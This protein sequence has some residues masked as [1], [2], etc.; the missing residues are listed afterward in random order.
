MPLGETITLFIADGTSDGRYEARL[1]NWNA[2]AYKIPRGLLKR[3]N[4]LDY[5]HTPGIYFLFG[6]DD[7]SERPFVYVGEA[8]DP[9]K[10]MNQPHPFEKN[11]NWYWTEVVL[12]VS[13]DGSLD[14]AKI[15]YLE[16]RFHSIA[17]EAT[18]YQ[19]L[20]SN[21]PTQPQIH[22]SV[23]DQLERFIQNARLVMPVLGH[24]VFEPLPS[25]SPD[26]HCEPADDQL[27]LSQTGIKAFGRRQ[28]DGFWVLRGSQ[29]RPGYA[30][31]VP[32]GIKKAREKYASLINADNTLENDI[33][34]GSP[35]YAAMFVLGRNSNGL[36]D[37][38][39]KNGVSLKMLDTESNAVSS[40]STDPPSRTQQRQARHS[41]TMD[42]QEDTDVLVLSTKALKA[43][44][45]Y[46][47][48]GGFLVLK[49]SA[50]G[51]NEQDSCSKG[52]REFRQRLLESGKVQ[53]WIFTEDVR[54]SSVSQA[55]S[56]ITGR[57][58]NGKK[59]WRKRE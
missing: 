8:E 34:F 58:A 22:K 53:N 5:I 26:N 1:G 37:W 20:N 3:S 39:T 23:R 29:I 12:F 59:E 32:S 30:D 10:R 6:M 36:L 25:G 50:M 40:N 9:F 38:K 17:S 52:N 31:Y 45:K 11:G 41:A 49:G 54:F 33:M 48:D 18:R 19:I 24:K 51:E 27:F 21:I 55:A 2:L 57:A 47:D 42:Q 46:L 28:S 4:D 56:C 13:T 14:K 15:K 16:N 44:G 43:R 7:E 35:S